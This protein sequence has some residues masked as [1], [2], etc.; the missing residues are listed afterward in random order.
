MLATTATCCKTR[1]LSDRTVFQWILKDRVAARASRVQEHNVLD[2]HGRLAASGG[3]CAMKSLRNGDLVTYKVHPRIIP[4]VVY[5][6]VV[7][8]FLFKHS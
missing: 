8:Q 2:K 5:T 6:T 4:W 3:W 7:S 1:Q